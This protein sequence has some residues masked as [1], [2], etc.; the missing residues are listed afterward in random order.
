[1]KNQI[2]KI[3]D[4][5]REMRDENV[6]MI[7]C[8]RYRAT[9]K[10][11][12]TTKWQLI[13]QESLTVSIITTSS[14][15]LSGVFKAHLLTILFFADTNQQHVKAVIIKIWNSLTF[16]NIPLKNNDDFNFS[17]FSRYVRR[18]I[19]VSLAYLA[20]FWRCLEGRKL[21]NTIHLT[22]TW[23]KINLY[24]ASP[25]SLV[26]LKVKI[27]RFVIFIFMWL[28]CVRPFKKQSQ[29]LQR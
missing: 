20:Y 26:N 6:P 8:D 4:K 18:M 24:L 14:S 16:P 13:A 29:N 15:L 25:H 12:L 22:S 17:F 2:I 3:F 19:K 1:M 5:S 23:A 28:L 9:F 11:C 7:S 21:P 10:M 27:Y